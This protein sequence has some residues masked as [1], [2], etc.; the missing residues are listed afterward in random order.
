MISENIIERTLGE[1]I[2]NG[3]SY[4]V[5]ATQTAADLWAD[6]IIKTSDVH[7]VATERFLAWDTFK[8]ES[9]RS[10]QQEKKAV[11]SA[12]RAI[13]TA[14]LIAENAASPFLK[15][16]I[17]PEYA[18]TAAGFAQW[19]SGFLPSLALWKKY[20]DMS[21]EAP[22]DEDSDFLAIYEKYRAFLEKHRLFDPA[23][24]TP[25][26]K[27]DGHQYFIFFPE[28]FS[29]YIEY[30]QILEDAKE[31]ITIIHLPEKADEE[32]M[33]VD[34]FT[35]S[36]TEIRSIALHLRALHK[37]KHL[38]WQSIAVHVPDMESYGPYLDR[39]LELFQ[40][41]HVIRSAQP[42]SQ[43][44]AGTFFAQAKSCVS[45][46]FSFDSV[47]TLLLN[48][49]LPWK[50]GQAVQQLIDFGMKN[51]CIC[52]FT[53]GGKKID[54]WNESFK[55]SSGEEIAWR[56]YQM[57]REKLT[58]LADAQTFSE[59]RAH[60]FDFR[61]SFFDMENCPEQ[62]D[63]II[64]R[65][66]SE[67]SALIDLE[68][69]FPDCRVPDCFSFFIQYLDT[70]SYLAQTEERGVQILPYKMGTC[71]PFACHIIVDAS[72]SAI[73][74]VYKELS[75]LRDDKRRHILNRDDTNVTE[76]F[77]RLYAMNSFAEPL[78]CTA[79]AKTFTGYAQASSYLS[80]NDRTK[81][82]VE[83]L[84]AG[85]CYYAEKN[86]FLEENSSSS[87]FPEKITALQKQS[88]RAWETCIPE[89]EYCDESN[90]TALLAEKI[91]E[92]CCTEQDRLLIS[93]THLNR[94]YH[95]P[96]LWMQ[97]YISKIK[98]HI[99]EAELMDPFA[100][101]NLYHKILE[102]Y[103]TE[104]KQQNLP[105]HTENG[106]LS[107]RYSLILSESIADAIETED[108][109]FLA[110]ELLRTTKSALSAEIEETVISFSQIF[111][112]FSVHAVEQRYTYNVPDT[113]LTFYGKIDCL[114]Y[115]NSSEEFVLVDFKSSR[116]PDNKYYG[117]PP[118][119]EIPPDS[120]LP[121]FQMPMYL[122]LLE[123]QNPPLKVE[124]CGF[125]LIKS[126]SYEP[127]I[128]NSDS[129]KKQVT[130]KLFEPTM[131]KF[132]ECAEQ[133]AQKIEAADFSVN[134]A[135]QDFTVCNECDFRAV[136]RRVFNISR[137]D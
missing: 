12:M 127:V 61:D 95:C 105:L 74:V 117:N 100:K 10:R 13:F 90:G 77:L 83:Q 35:D 60:Y 97:T 24:E 79:S 87:P 125:F 137:Q 25:P 47:K 129:E 65:C 78:Y 55:R 115:D 114:L 120:P 112:G 3:D 14:Q 29:D 91:R 94:F 119:T 104:L 73:S 6:R 126:H 102:L 75:F 2:K 31:N 36:R 99:N 54:V 80:E 62:S 4:F 59:I 76:D 103:C 51:N 98:P 133:F 70:K 1:Q 96:R 18:Q 72:Q 46:R 130:R 131:Q 108:N 132:R 118:E 8:G 30:K 27:A 136:C 44:G 58:K 85:D 53:Y 123:N 113:N 111:D 116:A 42:L 7:A 86:F 26:F 82:S 63:R 45:N 92:T 17:A 50:D 84:H 88:V 128:S 23:W 39:E 15:N 22:D 19:I 38:N 28:I 121:D 122:Y 135:E 57:L 34:F 16:C 33:S 40:I 89:T 56:F 64:S 101:G 107:E 9:I 43:T 37:K 49:E 106:T 5:F 110:K 134:D 11:P 41:P 66:I 21:G 81:D 52:S 93:A 124:N 67:L 32:M 71:A 20:F 48:T 68:Q 69:E 109:S